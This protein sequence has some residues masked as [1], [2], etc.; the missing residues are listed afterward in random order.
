MIKKDSEPDKQ[1]NTNNAEIEYN[2]KNVNDKQK[3]GWN[4]MK[5]D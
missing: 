5:D 4:P 2:I 1:N 3:Y